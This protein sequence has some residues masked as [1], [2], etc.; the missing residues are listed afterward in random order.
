MAC[1][2]TP[3]TSFC[4]V[5]IFSCCVSRAVFKVRLKLK[6]ATASGAEVVHVRYDP[7]NPGRGYIV[8][9]AQEEIG[10]NHCCPANVF[11]LRVTGSESV[12]QRHFRIFRFEVVLAAQGHFWRERCW[13]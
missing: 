10:A 13:G 2:L 6:A 9:G 7:M 11:S 3:G 8:R 12:D 1:W 4:R 5:E